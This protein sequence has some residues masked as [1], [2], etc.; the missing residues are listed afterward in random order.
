MAQFAGGCAPVREAAREDADDHGVGFVREVLVNLEPPVPA[1]LDEQGPALD[2]RTDEGVTG[3]GMDRLG[4]GAARSYRSRVTGV[5]AIVSGPR[6]RLQRIVEQRRGGGPHRRPTVFEKV[7]EDARRH[8]GRWEDRAAVAVREAAVGQ[9][10]GGVGRHAGRRRGG[11][12]TE[13]R[14]GDA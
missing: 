2:A 12:R 3:G 8:H 1:R 4:D 9:C 5:D 10:R 13:P 6:D 7:Q 14:D 11:R